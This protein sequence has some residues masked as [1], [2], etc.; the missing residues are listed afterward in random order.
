M[1]TKDYVHVRFLLTQNNSQSQR[2]VF[3]ALGVYS[4]LSFLNPHQ[5]TTF[6]ACKTFKLEVYFCCL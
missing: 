5:N 4:D 2:A 6:N 1:L 3:M